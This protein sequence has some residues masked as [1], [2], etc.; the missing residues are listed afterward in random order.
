M[1]PKGK[2]ADKTAKSFAAQH[3]EKMKILLAVV[4]AKKL[5]PSL[6]AEKSS[7]PYRQ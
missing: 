4:L 3:A 2:T 1:T 6:I 5:C 7:V